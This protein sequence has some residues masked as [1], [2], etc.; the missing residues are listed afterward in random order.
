MCARSRER[1][2]EEREG[3][4]SPSAP[5]SGG[6]VAEASDSDEDSLRTGGVSSGGEKR[7]EGGDRG[8]FIGGR[9]LEDG[10]GFRVGAVIDGYGHCR[11]GSGSGPRLKRGLTGGTGPSARE[12]RRGVPIRIKWSWAVGAIW[13]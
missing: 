2:M 5:E 6:D 7:G 10:L 3:C 9:S 8:L 4:G 1:D 11:A 12:R 13:C